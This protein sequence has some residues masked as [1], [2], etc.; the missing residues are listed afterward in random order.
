MPAQI[1][2]N[3]LFFFGELGGFVPRLNVL[4]RHICQRVFHH[5]KQ[6]A[7]VGVVGF[8]LGLGDGKVYVA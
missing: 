4:Q 6:A 1:K 2:T 8:L 5:I 7:L 3:G